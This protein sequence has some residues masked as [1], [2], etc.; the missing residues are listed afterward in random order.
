MGARSSINYYFTED[1]SSTDAQSIVDYTKGS[2][3]FSLGIPSADYN[4][5]GGEQSTNVNGNTVTYSSSA[6]ERLG[7]FNTF[8]PDSVQIANADECSIGSAILPQVRRSVSAM[9]NKY[10]YYGPS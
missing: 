9:T 10:P 2:G 5:G 8:A 1:T 3:D 4:T 7:E 6:V